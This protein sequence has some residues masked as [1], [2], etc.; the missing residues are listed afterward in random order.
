MSKVGIIIPTIFERPEYLFEAI[1]SI[2]TAGDAYILL[3]SPDNPEMV[4]RYIQHVD[5]HILERPDGNLASK[6]NDAL[7]QL[8]PDCVFIG[9]L[10][11][12]D[13]LTPQ[14]IQRAVYALQEN[15]ELG[16]VYGSCDYIDAAGHK[17]G[18]NSSGNWA[19]GLMR[20]GPFLIPQPGSFWRRSVFEAIGGI[21]DDFDL[22]FDHDLF[23][24]LTEYSAAKYLGATQAAFRWHEGS[25]SVGQRWT[26]VL[27]ASKVRSRHH[28]QIVKPI[29]F[30]WEPLVI[31]ATKFAGD[32]VTL[33]VSRRS[34][35]RLQNS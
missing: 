2:R 34:K 6:I 27:E 17:I 29:M 5:E 28:K 32:F 3:S 8:P 22:A 10:S 20:Y 11:D 21:D 24:R 4:S 14:S 18:R 19:K 16:L 12:D 25:L 7:N 13:L 23:L 9:W 15:P 33:R 35:I 30:L 31:F 1:E 26:S